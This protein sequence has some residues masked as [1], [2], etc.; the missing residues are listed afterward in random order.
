[1]HLIPLSVFF[2]LAIIGTLSW[3]AALGGWLLW[4]ILVLILYLPSFLE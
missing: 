2:V 4:E 1:M 3:L